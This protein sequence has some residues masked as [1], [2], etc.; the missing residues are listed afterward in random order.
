MN[1]LDIGFLNIADERHVM[2]AESGLFVSG[3]VLI[4][5]E[6]AQNVG[7]SGALQPVQLFGASHPAVLKTGSADPF[8]DGQLARNNPRELAGLESGYPCDGVRTIA[9]A[10]R[11]TWT[12]EATS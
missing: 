11:A 4:T 7:D 12:V 9:S 10:T 2:C 5:T 8:R 3:Q 6:K 1:S